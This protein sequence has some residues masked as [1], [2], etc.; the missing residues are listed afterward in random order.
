MKLTIR[1]FA[2]GDVR[3]V[4]AFFRAV[5]AQDDRV[6][7]FEDVAFEALA[8]Q[9][10]GGQDFLVATGDGEVRGV[11]L[12]HRY[13]VCDRDVSVRSFHIAVAPAYRRRGIGAALLDRVEAQDSGPVARRVVLPGGSFEGASLLAT[14]RYVEVQATLVMRRVGVPPEPAFVAGYQLREPRRPADD[15]G[16]AAIYNAAYRGTFAFAPIEP[17][18]VAS[19]HGGRLVVLADAG[20][21][22]VGWVKTLPGVLETVQVAPERQGSGLGRMLTVAALNVLAQQGY[23][24]VELT[25]DA[26]NERAVGLYERTGFVVRRRDL[27]FE[28][29]A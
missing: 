24:E 7:P 18:D 4:A 17:A 16:L 6:D 21:E 1:P 22:P 29:A 9:W 27:T 25:V 23:A 12:S 13:H 11:A 8:Q 10:A 2:A 28:R 15:A 19:G 20:G 5:H 3:S 14:R 26:A